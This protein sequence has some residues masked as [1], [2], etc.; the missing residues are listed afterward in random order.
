MIEIKNNELYDSLPKYTN[1][2]YQQHTKESMIYKAM[3]LLEG[4]RFYASDI[5]RII[6]NRF[7]VSLSPFSV[8]YTLRT[9]MQ[10][11]YVTR[12]KIQNIYIYDK[13]QIY[14]HRVEEN[15]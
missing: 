7:D 3:S 14:H 10:E 8:G 5:R 11:G 9:L 2:Q 6:K 13:T 4:D 12:H 15:V 1:N